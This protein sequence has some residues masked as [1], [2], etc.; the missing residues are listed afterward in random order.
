MCFRDIPCAMQTRQNTTILP[1]QYTLPVSA[2]ILEYL[3]VKLFRT[4]P[5][6]IITVSQNK[7]V[8]ATP[9]QKVREHTKC[10]T[11]YR[12]NCAGTYEAATPEKVKLAGTYIYATPKNFLEMC[13]NIHRCHIRKTNVREHA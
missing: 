11:K 5:H 7:T 12:K 4:R 13:G 3:Y 8:D 9:R 10:H 2:Y 6:I 1:D